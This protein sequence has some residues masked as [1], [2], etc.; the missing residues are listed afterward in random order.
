MISS[1]LFQSIDS[2]HILLIGANA[3]AIIIVTRV[4]REP[5]R[6]PGLSIYEGD[7]ILFLGEIHTTQNTQVSRNLVLATLTSTLA[8][9]PSFGAS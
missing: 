8:Y 1:A 7:D 4:T 6:D 9:L 2:S 5:E 3:D